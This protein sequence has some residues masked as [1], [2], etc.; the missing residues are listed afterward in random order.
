MI[1]VGAK[2]EIIGL[3]LQRH[4][5]LNNVV[6]SDAKGIYYNINFL[7]QIKMA[8]VNSIFCA[9]IIVITVN[10]LFLVSVNMAELLIISYNFYISRVWFKI[11]QCGLHLYTIL[12]FVCP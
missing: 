1:L 6:I 9:R 2:L 5:S 11:M 8:A 4:I 10:S 12:F 7:F 3:Q